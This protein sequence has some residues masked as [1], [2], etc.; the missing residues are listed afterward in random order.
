MPK[1]LDPEAVKLVTRALEELS[2]RNVTNDYCPRCATFDWNV[3]AVAINV[4]P[5]QSIPASMPL[6]YVPSHMAA[7]QIVCKNCGYTMLH[8][9]EVLGLTHSQIK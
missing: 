9:L 6:S 7:L 4:I 3:D 8:N 2:K 5:L 1:P